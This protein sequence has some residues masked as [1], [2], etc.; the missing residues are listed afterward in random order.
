MMTL[1]VRCNGR[2]LFPNV[3]GRGYVGWTKVRV[4][5]HNPAIANLSLNAVRDA[6]GLPIL[7]QHGVGSYVGPA[8]VWYVAKPTATILRVARGVALDFYA[9]ALRDGDLIPCNAAAKALAESDA[10]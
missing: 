8:L 7:A 6:C 9:K 10:P 3:S 1:R 5:R 2:G 4:P